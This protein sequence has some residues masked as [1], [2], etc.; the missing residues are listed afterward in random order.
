[1]GHVTSPRHDIEAALVEVER[2]LD[3]AVG[4]EAAQRAVTSLRTLS[5]GALAASVYRLWEGRM[6]LIAQA[7][8]PTVFDGIFTDFGVVGRAARTGVTQ[9]VA[10]GPD[11]ADWVPSSA[12]LLAQLAV[13]VGDH[14]VNFEMAEMV[15]DDLIPVF[16]RFSKRIVR[17][18]R[19]SPLA[20]PS[21]DVARSL[22]TMVGLGSADLI[23]EYALRLVARVAGLTSGRVVVPA[24]AGADISVAWRSTDEE[25]APEV[26]DVH[27]L[28]RTYAGFSTAVVPD[29]SGTDYLVVPLQLGESSLGG[30]V[31]TAP[32]I[33]T[34]N[35]RTAAIAAI[36]AHTVACLQ[37]TALEASLVDAHRARGEFIASLSH[38]LRT[39]M[40]AI[41]G[42][43]ELLL[44]SQP[45]VGTELADFAT[46]IRD[47]GRHVLDLVA[48]VLDVARADA[49]RLQVDRSAHL[50]LGPIITEV[51]GLVAPQAGDRGVRVEH[52]VAPDVAVVGDEVR[53]RQILT[54]LLS[55]AVKFTRDGCVRISAHPSEDMVSISI[56]DEGDGIDADELE[57]LFKPFSGRSSEP[58]QTGTGLGLVISRRLAEAMGGTLSLESGGRGMGSTATLTLPVGDPEHAI[59]QGDTSGHG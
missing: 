48:D 26:G 8:Y 36:A 1:M 39:P 11:D 33:D 47:S 20:T 58:G 40:T 24:V 55:N 54:N 53:V 7:G 27:E 9:R 49:G 41:V 57:Q 43:A 35:A 32:S 34:A 15:A 50:L 46:A 10:H 37:R 2:S 16:E 29:P 21:G 22:V 3:G 31:G 25:N 56:V 6:W 44:A 13:P 18:V 23:A 51:T 28:L 4:T 5:D 12:E 42:Y 52:E 30:I 17:K 38:E 59:V 19:S 45:V 14:V